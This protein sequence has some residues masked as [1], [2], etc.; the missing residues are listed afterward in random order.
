VKELVELSSAA[1]ALLLPPRCAGC[2]RPGEWLCLSCRLGCEPVSA[3]IG[4]VPMRAA[5]TYAG[6]LREAVQRFKYRAERGLS[7]ELGDL[8]GALVASDLALGVRIDAIVPIP[9]H[10]ERARWR[11]YDQAA[12]LA[13]AVSSRTEVPLVAALHRIA[14]AHPQVE[15]DRAGRLANV[16]GAFVASAGSL[17]RLRVALIDDVATTGATIHAA[18]RAARAAGAGHVRAYVVGADE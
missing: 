16:S 15:L 9:L 1:A 3:G 8:V 7:R 12:L 14:L 18:A 10:P 4:S 6:P 11:G 13:A 5:G 17:S 2:D